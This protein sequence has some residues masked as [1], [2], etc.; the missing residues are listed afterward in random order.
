M[1]RKTVA[2]LFLVLTIFPVETPAQDREVGEPPELA[3]LVEEA[4]GEESGG[5]V[6]SVRS[7]LY[8]TREINL[9]TVVGLVLVIGGIL[10]VTMGGFTYTQ[11]RHAADLGPVEVA[12][13]E[14]ERV[15]I[16]LWAGLGAIAAGV[17]VL[18]VSR[19]G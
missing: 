16:P 15:N 9:R 7:S 2:A 1:I 19:R 17:I 4:S 14:K 13:E 12:M 11:D 8:M 6:S 10:A 5:L 3:A 18:A